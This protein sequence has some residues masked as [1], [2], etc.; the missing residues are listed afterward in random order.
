MS[1]HGTPKIKKRSTPN[2]NPGASTTRKIKL[3]ECLGSGSYG[4]VYKCVEGTNY[5]AVKITKFDSKGPNDMIEASIMSTY[6][7]DNIVRS[8]YTKIDDGTTYIFQELAVCDLYVKSRE[9]RVSDSDLALWCEDMTQAIACLHREKIIHCDIKASNV[10]LFSNNRVKIADFTLAT[11][12]NSYADIF[13]HSICT[14]THRAPESTMPISWGFPSDI[15]SLGCTF[16][17]IATGEFLIPYQGKDRELEKDDLNRR[18]MACMVDWAESRNGKSSMITEEKNYYPI[19]LD[20]TFLTRSSDF[21]EVVMSMTEFDPRKRPTISS[22]LNSNYLQIK[23]ISDCHIISTPRRKLADGH[24]A[25][26]KRIISKYNVKV[27]DKALELYTRCSGM[28]G[29][30]ETSTLEACLWISHKL[31]MR[32]NMKGLKTPL[33]RLVERERRIYEYLDYRIHLA[34]IDGLFTVG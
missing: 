30:K 21:V 26:T 15:W 29:F 7:H 1:S 5:L 34:S 9:S 14:I 31:L 27:A 4:K 6:I 10:L 2:T 20:E 22:I 23:T 8:I 25:V 11:L 33:S 13:T 18:T 3:I 16:Y 24:L 32:T 17:E 19:C 28:N 12:A